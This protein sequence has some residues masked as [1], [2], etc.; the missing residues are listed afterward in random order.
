MEME[1]EQEDMGFEYHHSSYCC[2]YQAQT[3]PATAVLL[4]HGSMHLG[5]HVSVGLARAMLLLPAS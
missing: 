1:K 2:T 5:A 3:T 4:Y